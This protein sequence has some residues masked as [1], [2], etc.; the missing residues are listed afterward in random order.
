MLNTYNEVR[1]MEIKRININ[2]INDGIYQGEFNYNKL[3]HKVEVIISNSR[4]NKINVL[5]CPDSKY[6]TRAKDVFTR[7]IDEQTLQVDVIS[8]ATTSSKAYLKAIQN[9]LIAD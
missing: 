1:T 2:E 4:I 7:I 3:N 6:T 8:G 9:A 5:I